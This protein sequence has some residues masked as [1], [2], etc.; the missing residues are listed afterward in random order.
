MHWRACVCTNRSSQT[1]TAT[2]ALRVVTVFGGVCPR[3]GAA[4]WAHVWRSCLFSPVAQRLSSSPV[5]RARCPTTRPVNTHTCAWQPRMHLLH[6]S[7]LSWIITL[8][9]TLTTDTS[10]NLISRFDIRSVSLSPNS[11]IS[12]RRPAGGYWKTCVSAGVVPDSLWVSR[13]RH[14]QQLSSTRSYVWY[15]CEREGGRWR[16]NH[17]HHRSQSFH[18]HYSWHGNVLALHLEILNHIADDE[19]ASRL[20]GMQIGYRTRYRRSN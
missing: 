5:G 11:W 17:L 20:E 19:Y 14:V 2:C 8:T 3:G 6:Q 16:R 12:L 1:R 18:M 15:Y 9:V 10:G 7:R 4:L 13:L